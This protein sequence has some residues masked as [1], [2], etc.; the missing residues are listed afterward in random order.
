MDIHSSRTFITVR[1][2]AVLV[3]LSIIACSNVSHSS[4]AN[5]NQPSSD[6]DAMENQNKKTSS[7]NIDGRLVSANTRF[8]FKLFSGV[9][10]QDAGKNVFISPASVGL[11]LAMTYNGA[12]GETKQGME[13]ALEVQGMNHDELNRAY[14][15]LK[16]TLENPDPKVELTIANSLWAKKGITFNP[17]FIQR[18]KQF[19]GAEVTALDF[20]DPNAPAIINSWV[21]HNTKGKIDK[22]VD[23][24]DVQSILFLINAIYF[25]GKWAVEFDKAKTKEDPFTTGAGEQKPHPMM[26]QSGNYSYYEGKDFQAVSLP[27]GAGRVSMYIF[28]PAKGTSLDSFQKSLTAANWDGWMKQFAETK[29]EV[30]LP[31]FKVEY[32]IALNEVL[33]ALGMGIAFDPDRADFSGIVQSSER[34]FI[35]RVKHKT[36][37]EINEEGTEAAAVTSVEMRATSAMR[38]QKT[39]RMIVDHPFFCAIRD[40]KTGTLLFM[41]SITDPI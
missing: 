5:N 12:V 10:K 17:D 20:G 41:G 21:A 2:L 31:R 29:G 22:I 35:S 32:E 37:A 26:H 14:A 36:F 16:A 19:Y 28:L 40:N 30:V 23:Q 4:G 33:K 24:I 39:F 1:G 3:S 34:V 7:D 11:A 15:E 9:A 27:Y 13:R 38:P 25:K 6:N 8:G 18:N